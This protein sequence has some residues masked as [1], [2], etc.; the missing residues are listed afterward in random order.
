MTTI[1]EEE[2]VTRD[3]TAN[4]GYVEVNGLNMYYEIY[5]E[6]KPLVLI[7]G[8]GSTIQTTFE[9]AIPLLAKNRMVIA[10]ELQA[11]GRTDD[12]NTALSF[13]QDADDVV[14][15]LKK[16]GIDNA[17]FLG[18]S[19][20]G[21]T[22]L[23]IAIRYP[24]LVNKII[25]ASALAK[26]DGVPEWFWDFM[27]NARL[28]NMPRQLKEAYLE[29]TPD[30]KRLQVMHDKDA[31][32][33]VEFVDIPDE[34]IKSIKAPTLVL[35]GDKDVITVEHAVE[36]HRLIA[37]SELAVIPGGHGEYIGEV[38]TLKPDFKEAELVVPLLDKFLD[39]SW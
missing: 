28:E 35:I 3:S 20:G 18:F 38:T 24:H 37:N 15:L 9:K 23:H 22:T 8:G 14:T 30:V 29:L 4:Q 7:H 1:A 19:N 36:I 10:M 6:G 33:M 12:R 13:A 17:D 2:Q 32:R 21:T 5:G 34:K 26:R 11:H 16:L 25:L 39:K 27:D 31:R